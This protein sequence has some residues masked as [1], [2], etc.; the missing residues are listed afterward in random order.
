MHRVTSTQFGTLIRHG[1]MNICNCLAETGRC[2]C[3][4]DRSR[5]FGR[6][7]ND[8]G[9]SLEKLA[10]VPLVP[11]AVLAVPVPHRRNCTRP[12]DCELHLLV[13]LRLE[14]PLRV[15]SLHGNE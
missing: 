14:S 12:A 5:L 13:R 8:Q 11:L 7:H 10:T 6:P 9:A 3:Q 15:P 1:C 2:G 4:T